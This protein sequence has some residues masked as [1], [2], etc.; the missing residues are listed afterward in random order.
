MTNSNLLKVKIKESGLTLANVANFIGISPYSLC[1]KVNGI[2]D[3][4]VYEMLTLSEILNIKDKKAVFFA[5]LYPIW[6]QSF[7]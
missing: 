3:F 1:N 2:L 5:S 4:T 7:K 6:T